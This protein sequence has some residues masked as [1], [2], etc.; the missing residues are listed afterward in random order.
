MSISPIHLKDAVGPNNPGAGSPD[1]A[2]TIIQAAVRGYLACAKYRKLKMNAF[3]K[4]ITVT[5]EKLMSTLIRV[6]ARVEQHWKRSLL[7][8][9]EEKNIMDSLQTLKLNVQQFSLTADQLTHGKL[10]S[11]LGIRQMRENF[12][13][14]VRANRKKLKSICS[15]CGFSSLHKGMEIILGRDWKELFTQESLHLLAQY[16]QLF[17]PVGFKVCSVE[18]LKDVTSCKLKTSE[19]E[20]FLEN[21]ATVL[22]AMPYVTKFRLFEEEVLLDKIHGAELNIPFKDRDG[23]W[24]VIVM[25]GHFGSDPIGAEKLVDVLSHKMAQVKVVLTD[26]TQVSEEFKADYIVQYPIRDLFINTPEEIG[27]ELKDGWKQVKK[28]GDHLTPSEVIHF[29]AS[30]VERQVK[31]LSLML[32][33]DEPQ[34][35]MFLYDMTAKQLPEYHQLLKNSLHFS[36]QRKLDMAF[37]EMEEVIR[38]LKELKSDSLSYEARIAASAMPEEVKRKALEKLRQIKGHGSDAD[39]AEKYLNG[40]LSIPFGVFSKEPVSIKSAPEEIKGY[41]D[42]VKSNLDAAV[43]GH[44]KPKKAILEWVAQRIANGSSKGECIALEGPP[45]TGKTTF[46]KEG[47]SKALNRPFAFIS[48]GGQTDSNF[49]IGHGYTYVGSDWGRIVQILMEKKCNDPVIYIDEVDKLSQTPHGKEIIGVL[50]ALTDFSQNEDF[51]DKYFSGIKFDLSR[52][53]FVFSYNDPSQLDPIFKDR[54]QIIKVPA[55]STP[56][57]LHV[58]RRH[59]MPE[60]LKSTGFKPEDIVIKDEAIRFLVENYTYEAGVRRLRENLFSIVRQINLQR[61]LEP[62][63]IQLPFEIDQ[64]AIIKFRGQP[65]VEYKKISPN[66]MVGTVNGLY[67]T[68]AGIGGLT[69]VET[70]K[71]IGKEPLALTLTG[72]QGKVMRESMSVARSV[73]W[74]LLPEEVKKK[75]MTDDPEGLHIHVPEGATPKDGPSAGGAIT[76]AIVSQLLGIPVKNDVAMTGEIDLIGRISKI[77]GLDAKLQGAKRAGVKL[78]LVPKENEKDLAQIIEKF[79]DLVDES[80][81]VVTIESIHDILDYALVHNPI[82]RP[83][84]PQIYTMMDPAPSKKIH[85]IP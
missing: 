81:K 54:L 66:S 9:E 8:Q 65:K 74:N 20:G 37:E 35:A 15:A 72:S 10:P 22:N 51:Q 52:A 6:A 68:T 49:L 31:L 84:V 62:S 83:D 40:L 53:L 12:A 39:K 18:D 24:K 45:G 50:T 17:S 13:Q 43:W 60:I 27:Q 1:Q 11:L 36:L 59:Q 56:E 47:I 42:Q 57:K 73:A 21:P 2:A 14:D 25:K 69:I 28:F 30:P 58:A 85:S 77:G 33:K 38:K 19:G 32:L 41:L 4:E 71:T 82:K 75:I 55:L 5:S 16:K 26:F 7:N 48:L 34:V 29:V 70:Y 80:F 44:E 63:S 3:V 67:A 23:S 64:E 61:M 76:L 78:A 46:A 79:P